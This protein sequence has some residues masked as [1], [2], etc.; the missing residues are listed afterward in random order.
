MQRLGGGGYT[1]K[2]KQRGAGNDPSCGCDM[3]AGWP[4]FLT[5]NIPLPG[6]SGGG[7]CGIPPI[8]NYYQGGAINMNKNY[9]TTICPP[10]PKGSRRRSQQGGA[11]GACAGLPLPQPLQQG[12][13]QPTVYNSN[14]VPDACPFPGTGYC[15]FYARGGSMYLPEM[16]TEMTSE[17][18][19]D[20]NNNT[21]AAI[22]HRFMA[23]REKKKEKE[24]AKTNQT[25]GASAPPPTQKGGTNYG[26]PMNLQARLKGGANNNEVPL[27]H[28]L[29]N[30]NQ[31]AVFLA[32]YDKPYLLQLASGKPK[33][34][35]FDEIYT[36]G[37]ELLNAGV[38]DLDEARA[39]KWIQDKKNGKPMF[40]P[41]ERTYESS[42]GISPR[43]KKVGVSGSSGAQGNNS[44][45]L[46]QEGG[47]NYGEPMY[48]QARLKGGAAAR[49]AEQI[50]MNNRLREIII[51]RKAAGKPYNIRTVAQI[52]HEERRAPQI[53]RG[54]KSI[55]AT[56]KSGFQSTVASTPQANTMA[57]IQQGAGCGCSAWKGGRGVTK[58]NL[59]NTSL[60][61]I[62][63]TKKEKNALNQATANLI[64][65]KKWRKGESIGFSKTASLKAKGLIPRTSRKHKGKKVVSAKYK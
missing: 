19:Y 21:Q 27:G 4:K 33:T 44:S 56:A 18:F 50:E 52:L 55:Q 47:A 20:L 28:M 43:F 59:K 48:L 54:E 61:N 58:K 32:F 14:P 5:D 39:L 40:G 31:F 15:T 22:Y 29:M 35:Q 42:T 17:E 51:S 12:G 45:S 16:Q 6:Q 11:C 46:S 26:E 37:K 34:K 53:P 36:A 9:S 38:L 57:A 8:P 7:S 13:G 3:Q 1:R 23:A 60:H 10:Q 25:K 63:F 24:K 64:A 49:S 65:L 2:R 41:Q 30:Q 62:K